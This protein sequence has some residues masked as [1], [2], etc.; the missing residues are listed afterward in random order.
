MTTSVVVPDSPYLEVVE[1][2]PLTIKKKHKGGGDLS[3]AKPG[4]PRVE[5]ADQQGG[6]WLGWESVD[7][8]ELRDWVSRGQDLGMMIS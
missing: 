7:F 3:S 2:L 8:E 1:I 5:L 4:S 6:S